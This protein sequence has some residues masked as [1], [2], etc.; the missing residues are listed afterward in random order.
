MYRNTNYAFRFVPFL[1]HSAIPQSAIIEGINIMSIDNVFVPNPNSELGITC[2]NLF[3]SRNINE[4]LQRTADASDSSNF[5][6]QPRETTAETINRINTPREFP[7]T[8]MVDHTVISTP[9]G[10][11]YG[12]D[13]HIPCDHVCVFTYE[14][15]NMMTVEGRKDGFVEWR[16]AAE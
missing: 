9:N 15:G 4:L 6:Q 11:S 13:G 16:K 14:D 5:R 2:H 1:L 12:K 10:Q 3:R 8:Q 7:L